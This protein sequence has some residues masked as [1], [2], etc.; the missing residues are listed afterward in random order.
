MTYFS[1]DNA[2]LLSQ[3]QRNLVNKTGSLETL[4][5]HSKFKVFKIC[6]GRRCF[7]RL[8]RRPK[9]ILSPA[10]MDASVSTHILLALM[11]NAWRTESRIS[12]KS[13]KKGLPRSL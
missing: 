13:S 8:R 10:L 11:V 4:K 9:M 12:M 2:H 5:A 7:R 1:Q 6:H 3:S